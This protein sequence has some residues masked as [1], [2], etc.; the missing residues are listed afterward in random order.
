M[1]DPDQCQVDYC[2]LYP[3]DPNCWSCDPATGEACDPCDVDPNSEECFCQLEPQACG[4]CPPGMSDQECACLLDPAS[5]EPVCQ[6]PN[7]P[8]CWTDLCLDEQGDW[9]PC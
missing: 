8:D 9:Y 4:E 7:D 5:C 6:D 3:Q 1:L 2:D